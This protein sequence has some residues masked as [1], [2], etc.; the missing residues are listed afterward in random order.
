[1]PRTP[2]TSKAADFAAEAKCSAASLCGQHVARRRAQ[3][4]DHG[5]SGAGPEP[6]ALLLAMS[7]AYEDASC[8]RAHTELHVAHVIPDHPRGGEIGA[9]LVPG[10]EEMQRRRLATRTG[11]GELV[12]ADVRRLDLDASCPEIGEEVVLVTPEVVEGVEPAADA[13]LVGDDG[14]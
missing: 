7:R 9:Q 8:S 12:R 10:P 1:M 6:K 11:V 13:A 2:V 5:M 3:I 4:V 14:E